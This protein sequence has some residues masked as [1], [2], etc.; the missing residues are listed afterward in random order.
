[1]QTLI[2]FVGLPLAVAVTATGLGLLAER[3]ARARLHDGLLAPLGFCLATCVLLGVYA[4]GLHVEVAVGV[5]IAGSVAG[6]ALAG[7]ELPRRLNP[8]WPGLA[9]LAVY[10]LYAAPMLLSGGWTWSGYNFLNDTAVQFLLADHLKTA[11]TDPGMLPLTTGGMITRSYLYSGYP[12]GTHAYLATLSGL[13]ATPVEVLYQGFVSAMA[14]LTAMA[15]AVLSGRIGFGARTA[16]IL[17]SVAVASNLA[18]NYGLQ[19]SIKEIGVL[20]AL[21]AAMALG[22]EVVRADRPAAAAALLG[23]AMAAMLSV[24]SAAGVPYVLAVGVTLG[25]AVLLVHGRE[26]LRL[27]W[28]AA[29]AAVA[30]VTVALAAGTLTTLWQFYRVASNVVDAAAPAGD[31]LG[32]LSAPLPLLQAGGIWLDGTFV[33]PIGPD[34]TAARMTGV[35]LWIVAGL[36]VLG[37]VAV[38]RRRRPQA[39]FAFVPAILTAAVVAPRVTPYADA[40]LLAVMS[41]SVLLLAGLG[42]LALSG[43]WRPLGPAL[44]LVLV[45]G[46]MVSDA[47]AFHDTKI[48]PRDR[49]EAIADVA[50]RLPRGGLVMWNEFE[51]FAKYFARAAPLNVSAEPI[52]PLQVQLRKP[53][54][55]FGHY[56]DLDEHTLAHVRRFPAIVL[57]RSPDA[58]RPPADYERTYVNRYYEVWRRT[59]GG[60]RVLHHL[61][62]QRR[63]SSTRPAPCDAVR[64]LARRA[65]G[66]RGRRALVA[67]RAP[68]SAH[69]DVRA[70]R[71]R[72]PSFRPDQAVPGTIATILPG[73]ASGTLSV[74]RAGVHQVWLR[75]DFPRRVQLFVDGRRAGSVHGINTPGQWLQAGSR[76]R[77]AAGTHRVRVLLGGGS[78]R[79]SD[80][81]VVR[82]G[83]LALVRD[84]PAR[85]QTLPVKRWRT[86]CGQELDWIELVRP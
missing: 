39:L 19:G 36:S 33:G 16:A 41:P 71:D 32:H 79:P 43:L 59:S 1:M 61:P 52:T 27:R 29:A 72:S 4:L 83:P 76:L 34:E 63:T 12:L 70:A 25:A 50:E 8:G 26:S 86:L 7:R 22:F 24:Y 84:E 58:S 3:A 75:G 11:G 67:A 37:I 73:D 82:I 15:M 42:L 5:L 31:V 68:A 35:G 14:A 21:A 45:A 2:A 44:G 20:C 9:A 48:A 18:Y 65:R 56:F 40:K 64:R 78:L 23:V 60:P 57:R 51:E 17:A 81:A 46:I 74:R 13:L 53:T 77:L 55:I 69:F 62:L 6:F 38:I 47:Y 49:M 66:A 28:V 80:G 10:V 30:A 54:G 85:L